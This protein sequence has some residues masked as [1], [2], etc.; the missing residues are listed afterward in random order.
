MSQLSIA[1]LTKTFE[2]GSPNEKKALDDVSLDV[3]KGDFVTILGSNG[4][5]KSTLF[6][7]VLGKF[8]A[9]PRPHRPGRREHHRAEGLS[10][11]G[12]N[13]LPVPEP[14]QGN[15][16]EH[17]HRGEPGPG[18][19]QDGVQVLFA[20]NRKDSAYFRELLAHLKLGLEDR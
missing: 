19:Y 15:G 16:A 5:G 13:R 9:R 7:A 2:R 1:N 4:A 3:E 18:L 6:N 20:V 10:A 17:D 8:P 12:G 14:P 11:R